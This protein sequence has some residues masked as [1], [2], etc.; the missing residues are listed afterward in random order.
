[1][2]RAFYDSLKV[3][4][5]RKKI[6]GRL[7]DMLIVNPDRSGSARQ[8]MTNTSA[9]EPY[10]GMVIRKKEIIRLN[11][12][13]TNIDNPSENDPSRPEK[14]LNSTYTKTKKLILNK[15]LLFREGDTLSALRMADNE[16]LLRELPFI[17]DARI[18]AMPVDS[19]YVDIAVIVREKYP[20]GADV[21]IN[22]ISSGLIRAYDRNLAGLAHE[23]TLSM[24]YDFDK[25]KYPGFGAR[26]S[27]RNIARTFS[28][29]DLEFKDG[30]GT[31][32]ARGVYSREFVS[33]ET[34]YAWSASFIM[35]S[36]TE[37]LDTMMVPVPLNF[38]WQDYWAARS[39]MLDHNTVTRLI[40]T[41]RYVHNNVFSRPEIDD[42]S[43]Y[44][45]QSYK[46]FTG[47]IALSSQRYINT[48]LIYSYG[49]TEDI[50]YGYMIEFLGGRERNE[51][52]YRTY[53]G[54]R[55]SLGNVFTGVGYIYGGASFSTFFN[56][57]Q[58]EQGML[59][60]TL[61]YFTPLVQA[62]RSKIR[63]FINVYYTKG[64]NRY[65]DEFLFLKND[66]FVRGFRN[67]SISGCTRLAA[68]LEP[69][70]FIN[71]SAIGFRFAVF[72][73]ADY[74]MLLTDSFRNGAWYPVPALGA[75]IRIRNDQL[76]LNTM[77]IRFAWYPNAPPYS[78]TSPVTANGT[79]RLRP[80]DFEP[81]PPGVIPFR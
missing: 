7:Y 17:D 40:L 78:R 18:T 35:T 29:L 22:D 55:I 27:V 69:V 34:K 58:T 79:I 42:F 24:P 6:T 20:Y 52:K 49:R 23:L 54:M 25:Y 13:G 3:R 26:Y 81:A 36:T 30:L 70:M 74:G 38:T 43:F 66:D 72:A 39:V 21:R 60:A 19:N 8:R 63:T 67:D 11:A 77:Q 4:A 44:R 64:F 46:L 31:T 50:P 48:S 12:F 1:M 16:R 51:F 45:L 65:T 75:G 37:D 33:S 68:S 57:G 47:S 10:Q 56:H 62:G 53:A 76:V 2:S 41:A 32:L 80:P 5:E 14:F 9:L 61:R 71:R 15:H 59:S 73:F 28:N